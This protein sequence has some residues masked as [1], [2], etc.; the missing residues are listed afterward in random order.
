MI[1]SLR[2]IDTS[3]LPWYFPI[4]PM[5]IFIEKTDIREEGKKEETQPRGTIYK[6]AWR[7]G[8]SLPLSSSVPSL[9]SIHIDE[10]GKTPPKSEATPPWSFRQLTKNT[11]TQFPH[12]GLQYIPKKASNFPL[13][14]CSLAQSSNR[15][16]EKSHQSSSP[17]SW[18]LHGPASFSLFLPIPFPVFS[19]SLVRC[20]RRRR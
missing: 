11:Q 17:S 14:R 7:R 1:G 2:G 13:T 19:L 15:S 8:P 3:P 4:F 12:D 6:E 9:S 18:T 5:R 16:Q 10:G 20:R